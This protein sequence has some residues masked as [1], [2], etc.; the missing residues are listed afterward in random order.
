MKNEIKFNIP[1]CG[2]AGTTFINCFTSA[3]MFLEDISV[4]SADYY[5]P[6]LNGIPCNSCGNCQKGGN[7][8]ISMQEK[9]F[10]LFDTICGRSSLRCCFDGK[11]PEPEK[12]ICET[13]FYDSGTDNNIDFL[14]G[15]SMAKGGAFRA[16][17]FVW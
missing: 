17:L 1:F 14:F 12:M 5:C 15:G 3:F 10:F 16:S 7:T 2:F 6:Q 8:P 13:D 11:P 9:Y 4:G